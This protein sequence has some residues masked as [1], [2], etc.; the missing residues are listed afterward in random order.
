MH[1]IN[2]SC[3]KLNTTLVSKDMHS[4][5]ILQK[6]ISFLHRYLRV[7]T[8]NEAVSERNLP[9][10]LDFYFNEEKSKADR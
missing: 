10:H 3:L 2:P 6:L 1:S 4:V 8:T 9:E 5:S 7:T